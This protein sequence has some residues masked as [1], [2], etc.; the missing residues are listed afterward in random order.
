MNNF[1]VKLPGR[2][3]CFDCTRLSLLYTASSVGSSLSRTDGTNTQVVGTSDQK[4][5]ECK[6]DLFGVVCFLD[7]V[8]SLSP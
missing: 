1:K 5:V 6:R 8:M 3:N 2:R 4:I 7:I